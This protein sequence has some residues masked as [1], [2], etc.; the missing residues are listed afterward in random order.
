MRRGTKWLL[1]GGTAGIAAAAAAAY[2]VIA[3]PWHLRWGATREE[4]TRPMPFDQLIRDPNYFATRAITIDGPVESVWLAVTD[5]KL[6]PPGTL[7]RHLEPPRSVVFAPPEN[8]AEATWVVV[9]D[10]IADGR[11]RLVSRTRA[12][13]ARRASAILRYAMVDPALFLI[14]KRWLEEVKKRAEVAKSAA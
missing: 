13:F 11:T 1:F 6:L 9:L 8:E 10:A 7:I 14:E 2:G 5:Q 4:L 3:R 12:R